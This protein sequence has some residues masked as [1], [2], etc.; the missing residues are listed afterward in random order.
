VDGYEN[1]LGRKAR[2]GSSPSARTNSPFALA[3][4]PKRLRVTIPSRAGQ[5]PLNC[6]PPI[7]YRRSGREVLGLTS[8]SFA[9]GLAAIISM[10][11]LSALVFATLVY[12]THHRPTHHV[13]HHVHHVGLSPDFRL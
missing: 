3:S 5:I 6:S 1:P 2:E 7:R 10:C 11:V 12:P 4:K 8:G 13:L 9:F